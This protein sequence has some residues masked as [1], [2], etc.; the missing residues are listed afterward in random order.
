MFLQATAASGSLRVY[1]R[2]HLRRMEE[3]V[4][5]DETAGDY[6]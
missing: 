4:E 6:D 1:L 2:T 3:R 5:S